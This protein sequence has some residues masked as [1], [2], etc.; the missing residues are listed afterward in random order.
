M[1]FS[2]IK[3]S[4]ENLLG[5]QYSVHVAV[6]VVQGLGRAQLF[7]LGLQGGSRI[8]GGAKGNALA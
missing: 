5:G 3:I 8:F 7:L 2:L 6:V 4:V 1:K